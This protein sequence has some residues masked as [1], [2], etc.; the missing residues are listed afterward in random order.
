MKKAFTLAELLVTIGIVGVI[1]AMTI[2]MLVNMRPN[3]LKIKYMR[4]Y[5]ALTEVTDAAL[6]NSDLYFEKMSSDGKTCVGLGCTDKPDIE[7][8]GDIAS[9]SDSEKYARVLA[10]GLN[11]TDFSKEDSGGK[12]S[13]YTNDGTKWQVDNNKSSVKEDDGLEYMYSNGVVTIDFE[14]GNGCKFGE[15]GCKKPS[16]FTFS[17][18]SYGAI[19]PTD[20]LGTVFVRNAGE[21]TSLEEDMKEAK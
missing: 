11:G 14:G 15:E 13:F 6:E 4:T 17:Y 20:K 21:K 10:N 12:C 8:Y 9:W 18:D 3:D 19:A 5:N 2:P 7:P 16:K 1:T